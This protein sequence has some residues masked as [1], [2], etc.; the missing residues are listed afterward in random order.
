MKLYSTALGAEKRRILPFFVL[1]WNL[2]ADGRRPPWSKI[3]FELGSYVLLT[4][5]LHSKSPW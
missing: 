4:V 2:Q 1:A 3:T 5:C